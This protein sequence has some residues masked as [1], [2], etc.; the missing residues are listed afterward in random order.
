MLILSSRG[1]RSFN[2]KKVWW[3]YPAKLWFVQ[4]TEY[5]IVSFST[6]EWKIACHL[7]VE[8]VHLPKKRV[9]SKK[10]KKFSNSTVFTLNTPLP[11]F[12]R[13]INKTA[14]GQKGF[15]IWR[16]IVLTK[17]CSKMQILRFMRQGGRTGGK[18]S[19]FQESTLVGFPVF[20][21]F[22]SSSG[23]SLGNLPSNHQE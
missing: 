22:Q 18:V 17:A 1:H 2:R 9:A 10:T 7:I 16:G 23:Y 13:Y 20:S 12:I 3:F 6:T 11:V 14:F 8:Q 4:Y 5:C 19:T 21:A 15:F